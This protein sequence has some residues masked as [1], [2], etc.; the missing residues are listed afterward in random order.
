MFNGATEQQFAVNDKEP[1]TK[2]HNDDDDENDDDD[3]AEDND[4]EAHSDE[5]NQSQQPDTVTAEWSPV[6]FTS[7]PEWLRD[8]ELIEAGH[9][10]Q[11]A[12]F[13]SCIVSVF[14]IHSET[15]NIWTHLIGHQHQHQHHYHYD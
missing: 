10:P 12:N 2:Q 6:T 9:R 11:L 7:L 3:D 8:N 13:Y 5:V 14:S 4:A 15:G 1:S